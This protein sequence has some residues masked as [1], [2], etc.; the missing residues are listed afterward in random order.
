[1]RLAVGAGGLANEN[2]RLVPSMA[3]D[4][5]SE[6]TNTALEL[7][8]LNELTVELRPLTRLVRFVT[9]VER[10]PTVLLTFVR[11]VVSVATVAVRLLRLEFKL[12]MDAACPETVVF[13]VPTELDNV[14]KLLPCVLTVEVSPLT[15]VFKPLM[16]AA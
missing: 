16:D 1:M 12:V 15:V 8:L 2:M 7:T 14:V 13:K 10:P 6:S 4:G 3:P 5:T 11:D 9:L